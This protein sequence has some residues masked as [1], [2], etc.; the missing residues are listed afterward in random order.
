MPLI[1]FTTRGPAD[2]VAANGGDQGTTEYI[3]TRNTRTRIQPPCTLCIGRKNA[4]EEEDGNSVRMSDPLNRQ[5]R[6]QMVKGKTKV[7][8]GR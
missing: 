6:I 1:P 3:I 8:A 7:P 5:K 2:A 4:S